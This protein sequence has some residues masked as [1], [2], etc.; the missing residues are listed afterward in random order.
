MILKGSASMLEHQQ[1]LDSPPEAPGSH[2]AGENGLG[3]QIAATG[4]LLLQSPS[5]SALQDALTSEIALRLPAPGET[6][7]RGDYALLWLTPAEWLLECSEQDTHALHSAFTRRLA[8]SLA[9]VTDMSDAYACF[10]LSGARAAD[11]LMGGCSMD[12][13]AATFPAGRVARTSLAGI[14]AIIRKTGKPHGFRCLVDR[15]YARHI[16]DWLRM[17][18]R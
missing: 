2:P 18:T 3:V 4:L 10:D 7:A 8:R 6:C 1:Q 13:H 5:A 9:V 14:A 12:L 11:T 17:T 16:R 15:S